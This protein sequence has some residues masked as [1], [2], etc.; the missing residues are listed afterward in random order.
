MD[1]IDKVLKEV[2]DS[3]DDDSGLLVFGEPG[4]LPSEFSE[5]NFHGITKSQDAGQ[6]I[7]FID[8]GN[9]EIISSPNFCV[10]FIRVFHTIYKD[11]K[12]SSCS[13]DEFYVF[14]SA[15]NINKSIFYSAKLFKSKATT[16]TDSFFSTDFLFNSLDNRLCEK[17]TRLDITRV[18]GIMR[19]IAELSTALLL[20][21]NSDDNNIVLDGDLTARI[22]EEEKII[23]AISKVSKQNNVSV[24]ALSKTSNLLTSNGGSVVALLSSKAPSGAWYYSSPVCFAKLHPSSDYIFKLDTIDPDPDLNSIFSLLA[25]N[26]N[27]PVFLGYPYGLVEADRFARISNREQEML[28]TIFMAKAGKDWSSIETASKALDAHS[29]LDNLS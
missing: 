18:P 8:G 4:Q 25:A 27:D 20:A 17:D 19:R 6:D 12:R 5:D 7:I 11:R 15:R 10:H 13:S 22:S 1:I 2:S 9:A 23:S 29:V 24:C 16:L 14:C 28:K 3:A 26:S 21:G